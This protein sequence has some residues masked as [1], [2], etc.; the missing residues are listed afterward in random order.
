MSIHLTLPMPPSV[1]KAYA[2]FPKRH[3]SNDYKKWEVEAQ[4]AL[5]TQTKYSIEGDKWLNA[6]YVLHTDLHYKNGKKK[7][8]DVANYEKIV[9]DFLS[10]GRKPENAK[11][12]WFADHKIMSITLLKKQKEQ[13]DFIEILV[14]ELEIPE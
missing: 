1:N 3:K 10:W 6:M 5:K 7:V 9:S 2:G 13:D 12:L 4:K 8:I 14:D 11:I